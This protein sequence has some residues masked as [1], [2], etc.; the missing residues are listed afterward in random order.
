MEAFL[1]GVLPE[2]NLGRFLRWYYFRLF[3]QYLPLS[4]VNVII[5]REERSFAVVPRLVVV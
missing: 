5:T 2:L 3:Q 4:Q 1:V